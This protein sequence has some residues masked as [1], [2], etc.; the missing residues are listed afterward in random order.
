MP[1]SWMNSSKPFVDYLFV[2]RKNVPVAEREE[3]VQAFFC[4]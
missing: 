3:L 2:T 1:E 4:I